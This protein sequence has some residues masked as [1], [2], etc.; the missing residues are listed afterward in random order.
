MIKCLVISNMTNEELW[1]SY[2]K[3]KL[4]LDEILDKVKLLQ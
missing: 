1:L 3:K 4:R 2:L